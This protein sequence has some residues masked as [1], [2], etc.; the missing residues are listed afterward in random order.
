MTKGVEEILTE[1]LAVKIFSMGIDVV[2]R[3]LED[4]AVLGFAI[5]ICARPERSQSGILRA[6]ND[7][8][9]FTLAWC[10]FSIG[11][12]S[13]PAF[14]GISGKLCRNIVDDDVVRSTFCA[15]R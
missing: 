5:E 7:V 15:A 1:D 12:K 14:V 8:I 11:G 4:A 3:D 13:L 10:E 9:N 2:V 6:K